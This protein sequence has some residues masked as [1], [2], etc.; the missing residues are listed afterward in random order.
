MEKSEFVI[1]LIK[2]SDSK[3]FSAFQIFWYGRLVPKQVSA[4]LL[5]P[6][7]RVCLCVCA[8]QDKKL[9]KKF[10][11]SNRSTCHTKV[12]KSNLWVNPFWDISSWCIGCV[13]N[14]IREGTMQATEPAKYVK[15]YLC[16]SILTRNKFK[17]RVDYHRE[18]FS[19]LDQRLCLYLLHSLYYTLYVFTLCV[20]VLNRSD[21]LYM[22][23]H[24]EI[25]K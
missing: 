6:T 12:S 10:A 22:P 14:R 9:E 4:K 24:D 13:V 17:F 21:S 7:Y 16:E 20:Y 18:W 25:E 11:S 15:G 2:V 5:F 23:K 3:N 8:R 1:V 19:A